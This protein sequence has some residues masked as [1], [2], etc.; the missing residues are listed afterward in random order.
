MQLI[1]KFVPMIYCTTIAILWQCCEYYGNVVNVLIM[2]LNSEVLRLFLI[3]KNI[4]FLFKG[5]YISILNK[6]CFHFNN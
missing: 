2:S 4:Y 6:T 1:Y 3:I 5:K